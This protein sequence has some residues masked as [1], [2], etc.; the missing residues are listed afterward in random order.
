MSVNAVKACDLQ[1][2]LIASTGKML[3]KHQALR[4]APNLP[5]AALSLSGAR[6]LWS[7]KAGERETG[8]FL[9]W[10][11]LE[12]NVRIESTSRQ[13]PSF[14]QYIKSSVVTEGHVYPVS[15]LVLVVLSHRSATQG[16]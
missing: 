4:L 16:A 12:L 14:S 5:I 6:Q 3:P 1:T 11:A 8:L 15:C 10:R 2:V 13:V 7:D 9:G